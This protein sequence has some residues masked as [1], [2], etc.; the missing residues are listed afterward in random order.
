MSLNDGVLERILLR[1]PT[2]TVGVLG[3][4]FLDRYLDIDAALTEP[5][6]ETGLDAYQVVRVRNYPGAA[7]TVI[8]NLVALGVKGLNIVPISVAGDD[9]EWY[10]L[11]CALSD[12]GAYN[13]PQWIYTCEGRRTPTYTKPMLHRP[14]QPPRELNRLDIKNRTPLPGGTEGSLLTAVSKV[15]PTVDVLLVLDQVSEPECGVVT[16]RVREALA[17]LGAASPD[18]L[19]LADS[20]ERIGLFRSVWTKPNIGEC[21]RAVGAG[22]DAECVSR[23]AERVGRPVFCTRGA[24]GILVAD[25]RPG[26][27]APLAAVPAYRVDGPI[28]VVGA[29]DSTSAGIACALATGAT[30]EEAASFG[31]LVASITVRQIGTTG[32]ATPEQVRQRWREVRAAG[33]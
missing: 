11:S 1:I 17:E 19:I 27:R 3:D 25:P 16:T 2:L 29:G 20:R 30:L 10:D 22:D 26:A 4:L 6:I 8:N 32:T 23:L 12:I 24:E 13:A 33:A 18:K 21:R 5:S 28:D 7:G 14:G 31:N 9:G 15:L